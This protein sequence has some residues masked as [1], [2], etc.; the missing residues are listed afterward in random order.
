MY[1]CHK[2]SSSFSHFLP[3]KWFG[4][5][6][7]ASGSGP[8]PAPSAQHQHHVRAIVEHENKSGDYIEVNSS[9]E[10][11]NSLGG[12]SDELPGTASTSVSIIT[13]KPGS[14]ERREGGPAPSE[15]EPCEQ[16]RLLAGEEEDATLTA[17]V[18]H[19]GGD[20]A[21]ETEFRIE[22]GSSPRLRSDQA[23]EAKQQRTSSAATRRPNGEG[24]DSAA[25]RRQEQ[26]GRE[27]DQIV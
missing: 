13:P 15:E 11:S 21:S 1:A 5:S 10:A 25:F 22:G 20:K 9:S 26:E 16:T 12:G 18:T 3:S 2:K 4:S 7:E 27:K 19:F 6:S 8:P 17:V 23:E 14:S 24:G